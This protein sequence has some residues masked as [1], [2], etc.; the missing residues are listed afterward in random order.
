M[1]WQGSCTH[2]PSHLLL[3]GTDRSTHNKTTEGAEAAAHSILQ[4]G[5]GRKTNKLGI[6]SL[7][8][9]LHL[10]PVQGF[11]LKEWLLMRACVKAWAE[12]S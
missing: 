1:R 4:D 6:S 12:D 2:R 11:L 8:L 9:L 3:P 5:R 7:L 10:S